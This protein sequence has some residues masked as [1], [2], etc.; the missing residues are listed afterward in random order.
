MAFCLPTNG[1]ELSHFATSPVSAAP[2]ASAL[3]R[4]YNRRN[5]KMRNE[6]LQRISRSR[7]ALLELIRMTARIRGCP[8]I[9]H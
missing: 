8:C 9:E 7:Y 3:C 1:A 4:R 2:K 5:C 6:S